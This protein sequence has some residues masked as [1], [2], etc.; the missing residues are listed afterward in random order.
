MN[1]RQEGKKIIV[2]GKENNVSLRSGGA[3]AGGQIHRNAGSDSDRKLHK[4]TD[5]DRLVNKE[6]ADT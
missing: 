2:S 1:A 6:V 5:A 4:P 3:E